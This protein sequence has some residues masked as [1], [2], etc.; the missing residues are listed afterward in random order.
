[1]DAHS[2]IGAITAGLARQER[3]LKLDTPLG[4]N[5][6]IRHR[7]YGQSRIGRDYLFMIGCVSTSNDCSHAKQARSIMRRTRIVL[8]ISCLLEACSK[9]E[10]TASPLPDV[11]AVRLNL[12][13]ACRNSVMLPKD[14]K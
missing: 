14:F 6:L 2:M 3:L 10:N 9:S 5:A 11:S 12:A 4:S 1:M 8:L 13:F 7:A